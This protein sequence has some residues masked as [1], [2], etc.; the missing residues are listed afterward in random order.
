MSPLRLKGP[1]THF[2]ITP[3]GEQYCFSTHDRNANSIFR[4]DWFR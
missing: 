1:F 4:Y 3:V 2:S